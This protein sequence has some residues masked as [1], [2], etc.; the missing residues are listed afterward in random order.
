MRTTKR[1]EASWSEIVMT[2]HRFFV[3]IL[4]LV[5]V[6][7]LGAGFQTSRQDIEARIKALTPAEAPDLMRKAEG[8]D[9]PAQY[10]LGRAHKLGYG[11]GRNDAEAVKWIRKAAGQN[12]A[13]A[14][15][16]LA[17]MYFQGEGVAKDIAE[18]MKWLRRAADHGDS[19]AQFTLGYSLELQG[20][21][22]EAASLYR[23]AAEQGLLM[24]QT[25]IGFLYENGKGVR[26]D[27]KEAVNWYRKAAEQ[28]YSNA[29]SNLGSMYYEGKGVKKDVAE[30]ASWYR[31]SA[32]GGWIIGQLN[33]ANLYV[34]GEGVPKDYVS[35]YMWHS[36]AA[37]SGDAT[38]KQMLD[39]IAGKMKSEEIGEA[40]RRVQEWS[41]SHAASRDLGGGVYVTEK[42]ASKDDEQAAQQ[43]KR[44][45]E[46]GDPD[47]QSRLAEVY[48]RVRDYKTAFAWFLK[49]AD[50]GY[51]RGQYNLGVMYMEGSGTPKDESEAVKW[52]LKAAEQGERGAMNNLT[53][54]YFYGRG[55]P[56]DFVL[57]YM[58][59]SIAAQLGDEN[60]K[61][62]LA[63]LKSKLTA[64]QLEE[65]ER[66]ASQWLAE[67]P[68]R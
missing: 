2:F 11:V 50:Q 29:Q 33:L 44:A 64:A 19:M 39:A 1:P 18:G 53:A 17:N 52:F 14:E 26:Q 49:S 20:N 12:F 68:K 60:S 65:A 30:A 22:T 24:A 66:R 51:A 37:S 46:R 61:K 27:F 54:A 36:L 59:S 5:A 58:W 62:N 10:M 4:L 25:A 63:G 43:L 8:G 7:A 9:A 35:A 41:K 13:L 56:Q 47:A 38:G 32:E 48:Y 16:E 57:T 21:A 67:H 3:P 31:K 40:K 55:V 45:A 28:G 6:S 42:K 34:A 15:M 23:K